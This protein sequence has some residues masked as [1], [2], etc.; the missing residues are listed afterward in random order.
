MTSATSS[1]GLR[2]A[3]HMTRGEARTLA[4]QLE[5]YADLADLPR[6]QAHDRPGIHSF[7]AVVCSD[8]SWTSAA[9]ACLSDRCLAKS[10]V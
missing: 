6:A 1:T 2:A 5:H 3:L 8:S 4:R 9:V 7:G 10:S